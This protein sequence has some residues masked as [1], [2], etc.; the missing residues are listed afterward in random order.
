[1]L[2]RILRGHYANYPG[3]DPLARAAQPFSR[4]WTVLFSERAFIVHDFASV[5]RVSLTLAGI[6]R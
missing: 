6:L 3:R 4:A 2:A 5:S 1:M